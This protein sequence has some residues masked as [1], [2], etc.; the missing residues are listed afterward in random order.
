M[1]LNMC[2]VLQTTVKV[3]LALHYVPKNTPLLGKRPPPSLT[4]KLFFS[5][6]NATYRGLLMMLLVSFWFSFI[7][8]CVRKHACTHTENYY[9]LVC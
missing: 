2:L 6:V 3:T 1:V 8:D 4:P 5:R 9:T 7:V